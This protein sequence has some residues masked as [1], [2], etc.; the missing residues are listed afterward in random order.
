MNPMDFLVL[1]VTWVLA[2]CL[3]V[4]HGLTLNGLG[5]A[6]LLLVGGT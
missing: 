5:P 1:I 6:V 3:V 4:T 2:C